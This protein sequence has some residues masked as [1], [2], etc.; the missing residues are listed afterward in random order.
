MEKNKQEQ[1]LKQILINQRAIMIWIGKQ[2]YFEGYF[3]HNI[4]ATEEKIDKFQEKK[5]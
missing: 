2:P 5:Q 3:K 4:E 1:A